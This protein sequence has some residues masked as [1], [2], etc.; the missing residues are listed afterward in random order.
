MCCCECGCGGTSL[1]AC[2]AKL[3]CSNLQ[4]H[5]VVGSH[6]VIIHLPLSNTGMLS[7]S[8]LFQEMTAEGHL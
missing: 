8:I 7:H 5:T 6:E 4:K 1:L 2:Q 3:K